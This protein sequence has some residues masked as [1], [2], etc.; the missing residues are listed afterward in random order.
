L[1]KNQKRN[2]MET[3]KTKTT[4][5]GPGRSADIPAEVPGPDQAASG[6]S[7]T[8]HEVMSYSGMRGNMILFLADRQDRVA[9]RLNGKIERIEQRL[10]LLEERERER[11]K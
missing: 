1:I 4:T 10:T 11:S 7:G 8:G 6:M 9:E 5:K 3:N 2:N